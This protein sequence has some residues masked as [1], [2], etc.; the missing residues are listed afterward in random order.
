MH[1]NFA[2]HHPDNFIGR[3]PA[4]GAANP[5]VFGALLPRQLGKKIRIFP[6]DPG[7][8]LLI[9]FKNVFK[10][11]LAA[12]FYYLQARALSLWQAFVADSKW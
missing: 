11:K 6:F 3:D 9:V 1:K 10:H 8:P 7:R 5:Q 12:L 2:R 4:V